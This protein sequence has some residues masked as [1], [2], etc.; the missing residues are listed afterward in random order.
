ME[1]KTEIFNKALKKQVIN[2]LA[3]RALSTSFSYPI[4]FI[5]Y[6]LFTTVEDDFPAL[7]TVIG[8]LYF[9]I[10]GL[11]FI[12]SKKAEHF[13]NN[14]NINW[15]FTFNILTLCAALTW[16]SYGCFI[17]FNYGLKV[18]SYLHIFI[19]TGISAGASTALSTDLR[20]VNLF[21]LTL[22]FPYIIWGLLYAPETTAAFGIS[23][24][25]Y[26]LFLIIVNIKQNKWYI[27]SFTANYRLR[28]Q[29]KELEKAKKVSEASVKAKSSFLANMS[30][31]IR[32]PMNG[33]TGMLDILTETDLTQDQAD[34]AESAKAS[35]N[36]L[37]NLINDILD[38]SKIEESKLELNTIGFN[39]R[40]VLE[41]LCDIIALDATKKGVEFSLLINS[42]V[43][44]LLK[45][46]PGRIRQIATNLCGN[47][48]KFISSG[49]VFFSVSL[50][51]NDDDHATLLFKVKDTGIG[52][53]DNKKRLLFK[54]FSQ[55]D[56]SI[57]REFGGTGLG[58][59]ISKQLAE[60]MGGEIG[61]ESTEKVG[62]TFWFTL[63]LEKQ[64]RDDI[65][66]TNNADTLQ[67]KL[68]LVAGFHQRTE[69]IIC[70]YLRSLGIQYQA[71]KELN[72]TLDIM[73]AAVSNHSISILFTGDNFD[74]TQVAYATKEIL[75]YYTDTLPAIVVTKPFTQKT[76][77]EWMEKN[78]IS[79]TL[80][81]PVK[82]SQ[83]ELCLDT[84]TD[85]NKPHLQ[86]DISMVVK[87]DEENPRLKILLAEDNSMNQKVAVKML[88]KL[89]H[90]VEV[91]VNGLEAVK[92]FEQK[93]FDLILMDGQMPK[94][95]GLEATKKIRAIE[96]SNFGRIKTV[97]IVAITA[98]A[99]KGDRE[100]FLASGMDDYLTKPLKKDDLITIIDKLFGTA[101]L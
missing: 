71:V 79:A 8:I 6:I 44:V 99:M 38:F 57:T 68:V 37:L 18:E 32:T 40:E 69:M 101:R 7:T 95:S 82:L 61:F 26:V 17:C 96:K 98:N 86:A 46:D 81:K 3:E 39:L 36:S 5:I 88:T 49:E 45:G 100:R 63:K 10:A 13:I 55:V 28:N 92:E 78:H 43:P 34:L 83:L 80:L 59:T 67:D 77:M 12:L 29:A 9:S 53:P 51:E 94:M 31:E 65:I 27:D 70:E 58:L 48:V 66:T 90:K 74:T 56:A 97:P 50:Q 73:K 35:A 52:I 93:E 72:E 30:H 54:S 11:R 24:L 75:T 47:A 76:D 85:K 19:A 87:N 42:D 16:S 22:L 41:S 4:L 91:A 33:V 1:Q 23:I 15:Y 14:T 60:M 2:D 25:I 62:S 20:L 84:I 21:I 64:Q 89:G